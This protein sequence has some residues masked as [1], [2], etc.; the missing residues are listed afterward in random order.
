MRDNIIDMVLTSIVNNANILKSI[1]L[2]M[3]QRFKV[4]LDLQQLENHLS[5]VQLETKDMVSS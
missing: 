3:Q 2:D 5:T 1:Q 4:N